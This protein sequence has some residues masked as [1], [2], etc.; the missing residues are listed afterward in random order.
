M[1]KSH[2][3]QNRMKGLALLMLGISLMVFYGCEN[4]CVIEEDAALE[5]NNTTATTRYVPGLT[6]EQQKIVYLMPKIESIEWENIYG[7]YS[8]PKLILHITPGR[9]CVKY[10]QEGFTY[11][12]QFGISDNRNE[13]LM[14]MTFKFRPV[15][16]EIVY[17]IH[18][19]LTMEIPNEQIDSIHF[20]AV[21]S[22]C[23]L[24][25]NG[26]EISDTRIESL[27]F[28]F[29]TMLGYDMGYPGPCYIDN[30]KRFIS[31]N[32]TF[33]NIIGE[34]KCLFAIGYGI[35]GPGMPIANNYG[36]YAAFE[37]S[38]QKDLGE[39][40]LYY[41]HLVDGKDTTSKFVKFATLPYWGANLFSIKLNIP[42][43][44]DY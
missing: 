14:P 22:V 35:N 34:Q 11:K 44:S 9:E 41:L 36:N 3:L 7:K 33:P 31:V 42:K 4:E 19:P 18:Q 17:D 8:P 20:M 25:N 23:T 24:Y 37:Y 6:Q 43:P 16:E 29:A 12:I 1:K 40:S 32:I 5:V 26:K 28:P 13:N 15:A 2:F 21:R 39:M 30:L 27:W 10:M 38:Y